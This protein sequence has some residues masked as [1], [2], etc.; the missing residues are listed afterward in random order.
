[1]LNAGSGATIQSL[2]VRG[3]LYACTASYMAR[4]LW[5]HQVHGCRSGNTIAL[6]NCLVDVRACTFK[7]FWTSKIM[8]ECVWTRCFLRKC[9]TNIRMQWCPRIECQ[10]EGLLAMH[11]PGSDRHVISTASNG[12]DLYQHLFTWRCLNARVA[13]WLR[14]ANEHFDTSS[15]CRSFNVWHGKVYDCIWHTDWIDEWHR[16][17]R[18]NVETINV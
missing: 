13:P 1:M 17:L 8:F 9:S 11:V 16:L 12:A 2:S 3:L 7:I 18:N 5:V 4:G 10:V 6:I 15:H 14:L